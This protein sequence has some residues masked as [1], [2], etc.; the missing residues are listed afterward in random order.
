MTERLLM[1]SGIS[2]AEDCTCV[3][4]NPK[5]INTTKSTTKVS[6]EANCI[7]ILMCIFSFNFYY[8]L[9]STFQQRFLETE[10][11]IICKNNK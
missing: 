7:G 4:S 9:L 8:I 10:T 11:D 5:L 6:M 3:H 2:I 1:L